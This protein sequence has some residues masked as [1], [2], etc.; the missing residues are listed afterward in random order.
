MNI[1]PVLKTVQVLTVVVAAV[2]SIWSFNA[3]REKEAEARRAEAMKPLVELR[4]KLYVEA[5]RA[6]AVL[7]DPGVYSKNEI[8]SA[9]KRFRQLYIV[10]LSMVESGQVE[11]QMVDFAKIVDPT[12]TKLTEAQRAAYNLAHG[13]ASSFVGSQERR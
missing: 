1:E 3:T 6:A 7:A 8:L 12:L 10:E 13:L 4:Q 9:R 11:S 2:I 5:A